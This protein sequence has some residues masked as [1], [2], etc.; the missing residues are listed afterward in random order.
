[1]H[2]DKTHFARCEIR[3]KIYTHPVSSLD[4]IAASD[5]AARE[6]ACTQC[7][8]ARQELARTFSI[9]KARRQLLIKISLPPNARDS[10]T[11][12]FSARLKSVS[13]NLIFD[14]FTPPHAAAE[15]WRAAPPPI[16]Q[17]LHLLNCG[18]RSSIDTAH[19]I[20]LTH[21][22]IL[23]G[24][25]GNYWPIEPLRNWMKMHMNKKNS[26]FD[27]EIREMMPLILQ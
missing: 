11:R 13:N 17:T 23:N 18:A 8:F 21:F 16:I 27:L 15:A 22:Y 25:I 2:R 6:L 20:T 3:G 24:E 1:M 4:L 14:R 19:P 26:K 7:I 10:G 9:H 12:E 5:V